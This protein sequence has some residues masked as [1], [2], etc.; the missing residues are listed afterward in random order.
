[1]TTI[2]YSLPENAE[3][4]IEIYNSLGELVSTLLNK[5]MEAGYQKLSF[6]ANNL[7]SGT[8]IYQIK[9][10]GQSKS[11]VDSKKMLLVK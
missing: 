11:F 5:Q 1:M 4:S 9:A 7:P 8:Y 3:V 10:K 2:E 6:N